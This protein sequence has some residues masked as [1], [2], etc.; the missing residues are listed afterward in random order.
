M[1]R[2]PF[3]HVIATHTCY[4]KAAFIYDKSAMGLLTL[5]VEVWASVYCGYPDVLRVDR[6]P[7]F[8]A[9]AFRDSTARCGV[10]IQAPGIEVHNTI[11]VGERYH[12]PSRRVL[13]RSTWMMPRY[14]ALSPS[15]AL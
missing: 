7:T 4:Q 11:G 5:F 6:E 1:A 13:M 3:L 12:D 14:R 15:A 8:I 10:V 9:S 2:K